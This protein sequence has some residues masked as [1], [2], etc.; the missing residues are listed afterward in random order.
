MNKEK[1]MKAYEAPAA[2]A[3]VMVVEQCI[4]S[5]VRDTLQDMNKNEVYDEEF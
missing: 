1:L 3:I 5:S 4:A 2:T